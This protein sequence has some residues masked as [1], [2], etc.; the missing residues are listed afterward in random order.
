[1]NEAP[2]TIPPTPVPMPIDATRK[3]RSCEVL[4]LSNSPLVSKE[5]FSK[6]LIL[7]STAFIFVEI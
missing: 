4:I 5:F 3:I 6:S 1:M 2:I 7:L